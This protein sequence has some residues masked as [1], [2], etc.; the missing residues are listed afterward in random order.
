[1][2][3]CASDRRRPWPCSPPSPSASA[4]SADR[5]AA[6]RDGHVPAHRHRGLHGAGAGAGCHAIDELNAEH[7]GLVR[8]AIG[9]N[10]RRGRAHRGRRRLR[11][12]RRMPSAAARA[13]IDIQRAMARS[14]LAGRATASGCVSA[15]TPG[16]RLPRRRRLRR[17]RGQPCGP[18][19]GCRLGRPDRPLRLDARPHRR[20]ARSDLE[21]PRAGTPP[22]QG[23]VPSRSR[24]SSSRSPGLPSDFPPLRSGVEPA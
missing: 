14:S 5:D 13:A 3:S 23:P 2:R 9:G 10:A 6:G 4:S 16:P 20:R 22:P 19:R 17:L 15:S 1:M 7:H 18:H 24:C 21:H 8:A 11:G 12:L